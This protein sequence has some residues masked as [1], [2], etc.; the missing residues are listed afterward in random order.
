MSAFSLTEVVL[1]IGIISVAMI[2]MVCMMPLGLR[3]QKDTVDETAGVN[4]LTSIAAD[5]RS[6]VSGT[7]AS[8]VYDLPALP[9]FGQDEVS[10]SFVVTDSGV[11]TTDLTTARYRIDYQFFPPSTPAAPNLLHFRASWPA[12]GT[13]A[14][15]SV[16][17][18]TTMAH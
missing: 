18:V 11:K 6:T 13:S 12:T 16:E 17:L 2:P 8:L 4:I 15:D 9:A 14:T 5:R 10:N 7:S 3:V 1:A